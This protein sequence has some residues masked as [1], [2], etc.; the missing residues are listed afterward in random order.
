V[1]HPQKKEYCPDEEFFL[2]TIID[3]VEKELTGEHCRY[4]GISKWARL[5]HRQVE[6]S[7][8][9]FL[10]SHLDFLIRHQR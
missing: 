2:H 3:M 5:R 10:A 8:L 1:I 9:S 4:P 6:D 7:Q